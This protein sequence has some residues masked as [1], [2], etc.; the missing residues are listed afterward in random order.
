MRKV[1]REFD[2]DISKKIYSL[3]PKNEIVEFIVESVTRI[4]GVIPA[5]IIA[6]I[7]TKDLKTTILIFIAIVGINFFLVEN[8]I[9]KKIKRIRPAFSGKRHRTFSF[10]STHSATMGMVAGHF[11]ILQALYN[12][13]ETALISFL[14]WGFAVLM[15]RIV[16]GYHFFLDVW[17]GFTLGLVL[18]LIFLLIRV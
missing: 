1:I 3:Q 2:N 17:V 5:L 18:S 14:I 10:P 16:Y 13:S 9:K 6:I 15:S 7:F 12:H 4:Y 11:I 8:L